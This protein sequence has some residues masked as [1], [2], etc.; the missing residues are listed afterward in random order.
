MKIEKIAVDR[1]EAPQRSRVLRGVDEDFV[2]Q[3]ERSIRQRGLLQPMV[4]RDDPKRPGHFLVVD[5]VQRLAALRLTG[6]KQPIACVVVSESD[7]RNHVALAVTANLMRLPLTESQKR[8]SVKRWYA[9]QRREARGAQEGQGPIKDSRKGE[10]PS[11]TSRMVGF[12]DTLSITFGVT[13]RQAE[14][15]VRIARVFNDK[16]LEDLE[17]AEVADE[18]CALIATIEDKGLRDAVVECVGQITVARDPS[19]KKR[20]VMG[21]KRK[22]SDFVRFV[23]EGKSL[24]EALRLVVQG[25]KP[26][27]KRKGPG[28]KRKRPASARPKSPKK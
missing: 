6:M 7:A 12:A 23:C 27:L 4:V 18:T 22:R 10:Q 20:M 14:R 1:I 28:G 24:D 9:L 13:K 3:L 19:N 11:P 8:R 16:Q 2:K 26:R 25:K 5:G 21:D 17:S 15:Y